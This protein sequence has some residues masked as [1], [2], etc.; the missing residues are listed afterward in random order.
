MRSKATRAFA[1]CVSGLLAFTAAQPATAQ[2][3]AGFNWNRASD[4]APGAEQGSGLNNPGP[5][6]VGSAVWAYEVGTGG[7]L[8]TIDPWFD[9]ATRPLT[10]DDAWWDSGQGA[11]SD[12][13]NV[14]PPI[15]ANRM[16]HNL[17]AG[18]I[19]DVPIIRWHN[20]AG[21]SAALELTG[22]LRILWT[23]DQYIGA[24]TDV[25]VVVGLHDA[26]ADSIALLFQSTIAKPHQGLSVGDEAEVPIHLAGITVDEG[27][28]IFI[29]ARGRDILPGRWIDIH[30]G[31][32]AITLVPGPG[33]AVLLA[34]AAFVAAR[35]RRGVGGLDGLTSMSP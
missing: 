35:R 27:D 30:D 32:M 14:N 34:A 6:A 20:P 5:D 7:G 17:G 22:A 11:W 8:N 24:P 29:S 2:Y 28:S 21:D 10:W 3:S 12:G 4:W 19:S 13:D 15:F 18:N 33:A 1:L 9:G 31:Q 25:D 23:G 16:T 26:S